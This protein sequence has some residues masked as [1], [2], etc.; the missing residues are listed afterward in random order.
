MNPGSYGKR[1]RVVV[2]KFAPGVNET[3]PYYV[4]IEVHE[5]K[6][7]TGAAY[8]RFDR[9]ATFYRRGHA[10]RFAWLLRQDGL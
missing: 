7:G 6:P 3:E 9:L 10:E 5:G 8:S 1:Y 2:G 4:G